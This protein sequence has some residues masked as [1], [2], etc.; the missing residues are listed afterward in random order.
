MRINIL[1]LGHNNPNQCHRCAAEWQE[2]STAEKL[3]VNHQLNMSQSAEVAEKANGILALIRN[4]VA[5]RSREAT[6]WLFPLK[7][8]VLFSISLFTCKVYPLLSRYF[9]EGEHFHQ[10]YFNQFHHIGTLCDYT[11]IMYQL[12][13]IDFDKIGENILNSSFHTH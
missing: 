9:P 13:T 11:K 1:F 7:W 12:C 8:G 2:S 5:N 10:K 4:S 3:L 6:V